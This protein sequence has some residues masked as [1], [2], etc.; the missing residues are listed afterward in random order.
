MAG[1]A[2]L[3]KR[4]GTLLSGLLECGAFCGIIFGWASLVFVLKDLGYFEGLCQPSATPGP[5]LTL[6]SDCSGQDEQFSLVFTIG[7]FMNNFMTF[8]MGVVFDR[9]GTTA[10]APHRHLPL[11]WR[12]PA[13]RL[14]HP[15]AGGA[16]LPGHVHAVGGWH[17][18]HPHQHAGGEPVW[19]LPLHHHHPLQR[20]LR[21]LLR[22]LPHRQ[23]AVRAGA[24]PAG[25]VP[26]PGSLQC[27]APPAHPLP[28]AAQPHPLPAAPRLRLRAA[29]L[30]PFPLLPSPQGQANA[31]R[32]RTRGD[33]PGAPHSSRWGRPRD[34]VPGLRLLV[35]LRLARGLALGDAAAP[36]PVHRHPQPA[37]G[38][39]GARGPRPGEHVHQRL[40]LHPALR[41]ALCPLERP[42]PRP[43][44]A[45][46]GP[47]PRGDPGR[48][49]RPAV[50][51]AVAGG[52]GGAVPAVLRV[53][54]RACPARPVRHLRA[55]GHQPLLPVR[56][57]RRLPG[58]RMNL[59]LITMVLVAFVSPV[60]VARECQ[61]RA[62]E[63]GMAGTPLAAP[64]ST[65]IHAETPH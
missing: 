12:D 8:P 64:P 17:P 10:A 36:L 43:A 45:G 54:R 32:G 59:G 63:L 46:K 34:A 13:R 33:T 47:P 4:L 49:G 29:V 3:A 19:E 60:V 28:D 50:G 40:C 55:A 56:R 18:P 20:G 48:A 26:L 22:H 42:H 5:N 6:G 9:F 15:R 52:D 24:V 51:G 58:H 21:L 65:E 11:H 39:P 57:Q 27:L 35:A 37:A 44:Q 14:L 53:G 62:K 30:G 2:G 16:A 23:A 1:G 38:A 41:G 31:G 61:R 25:H 7:S